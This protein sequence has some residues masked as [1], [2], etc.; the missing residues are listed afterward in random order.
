MTRA[1][2][3]ISRAPELTR[4]DLSLKLCCRRP[5]A[6]TADILYQ[7][8]RT[9]LHTLLRCGDMYEDYMSILFVFGCRFKAPLRILRD[10]VCSNIGIA[11]CV[12]NNRRPILNGDV[13]ECS[14]LFAR[15]RA[16]S[17][18]THEAPRASYPL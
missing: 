9:V 8:G 15:L 6:C 12:H 16:F 2:Q 14:F 17:L 11:S 5:H 10:W 1:H 13:V 18:C 7:D 4:A 3:A